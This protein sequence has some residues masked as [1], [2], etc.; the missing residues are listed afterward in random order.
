MNAYELAIVRVARQYE[1]KLR[2]GTVSDEELRQGKR[3]WQWREAILRKI[4]QR[5]SQR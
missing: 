5:R 3:V 1:E 2:E 4:E